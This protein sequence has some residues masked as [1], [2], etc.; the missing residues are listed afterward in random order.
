M[1]A[2]R[3]SFGHSET[4]SSAFFAIIAYLSLPRKM[5]KRF[6]T[7]KVQTVREKHAILRCRKIYLS[8]SLDNDRGKVYYFFS[9]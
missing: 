7:G 3:F 2:R 8:V 6:A 1:N 9:G 5:Q 4:E